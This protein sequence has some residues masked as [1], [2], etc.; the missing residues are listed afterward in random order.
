M[1]FVQS[2]SHSF[3]M[4]ITPITCI[5]CQICMHLLPLWDKV[6]HTHPPQTCVL[7]YRCVCACISSHHTATSFPR[8]WLLHQHHM[9]R[10]TRKE[11]LC[12]THSVSAVSV[13]L[14][15]CASPLIDDVITLYRNYQLMYNLSTWRRGNTWECLDSLDNNTFTGCWLWPLVSERF[16]KHQSICMTQSA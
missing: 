9:A 1:H 16:F 14:E 13:F 8:R 10:P 6:T 12:K 7:L 2:E 4:L 3:L 15:R 5:R 11:A